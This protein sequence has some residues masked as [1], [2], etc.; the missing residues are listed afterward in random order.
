MLAFDNTYQAA[1]L[2]MTG[3][4]VARLLTS[5]GSF[6]PGIN[7]GLADAGI[8]T[9]SAAYNTFLIVAQ[10]L[11]DPGDPVN[12]AATIA[13]D[14]SIPLHMMEVVGDATVPNNVPTAPLSGTDPLA[15]LLGQSQI[16]QTSVNG[17][18]VKFTAGNHNSFID[19]TNSLAATVEMQ[20]QTAAFAASQGAQLPITDASVIQTLT[21]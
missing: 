20:K 16:D 11:L 21:Q 19:P 9:D 3:G 8:Q 12:H 17:G 10:T 5:S 13:E 4:G 7:Q 6:G 18:L 2:A 1:T 15:R 14:G